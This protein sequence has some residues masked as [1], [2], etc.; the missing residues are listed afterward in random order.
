[1]L[2]ALPALLTLLFLGCRSSS[3]REAPVPKPETTGLAE[4]ASPPKAEEQPLSEEE[5][6][7]QRDE[8]STAALARIPEIKKGLAKLRELEFRSAVPGEMQSTEDF[9]EFLK[10]TIDTELPVER[11]DAIATAYAQLGLLE[12]KLDLRKTL[13]DAMVSQAGAYYDPKAKKFFMVMVPTQDLLFDTLTAHELTHALQDQH[14]DLQA[15]YDQKDKRLVKLGNDASNARRF[16]VEGEATLT[17]MAYVIGSMTKQDPLSKQFL[18]MLETQL[19]AAAKMSIEELK[20]A[21]KQQSS[22]FIDM[23]EDIRGAIKA[24]DDIPLVL[25]LP[26]L[27]SYMRGALPVFAAFKQG[28][29][30]EV[31]NLYKQ[32]PESTEQVL[33][34]ETKLFP[35]RDLPKVVTLPSPPAGYQPVYSDTIGEL[36][37]RV[38]FLLW[39][40]A[41]SDAAAAGWDGDRYTVLRGKS[42]DLLTLQVTTWDSEGEAEEFE[43]AYRKSL[44]KRF[45]GDGD[46]RPAGV[47]VRVERKG[48]DVFIVDG[49][50]ADKL[51]PALIK[52]TKIQAL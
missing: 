12:K 15:Y 1:M 6:A 24:M 7:K 27:E 21:S 35:T 32:P 38:Y 37:W 50:A 31:N 20:E 11:A 25:M 48:S 23:G 39:E 49:V 9:R 18:P 51:M 36:E 2:P 22:S 3:P 30:K 45:G 17:M 47:P 44:I 40:K 14:F 8:R 46:K 19:K 10:T 5:K 29:W 16:I 52:G 26:L 33:H 4:P 41:S 43:A 34:P 42:G 28:G 13:E